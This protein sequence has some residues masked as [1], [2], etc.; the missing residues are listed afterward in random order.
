M[1]RA[2]SNKDGAQLHAAIYESCKKNSRILSFVLCTLKIHLYA[3][4]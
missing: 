4:E 3:S 2:S 1:V